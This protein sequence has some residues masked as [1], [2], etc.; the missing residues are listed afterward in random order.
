MAVVG[1]DGGLLVR[2]D[3]APERADYSGRV[4]RS[5]CNR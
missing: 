1:G 5:P 3:D 2:H 4:T